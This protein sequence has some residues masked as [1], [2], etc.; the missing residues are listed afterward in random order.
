MFKK[1]TYNTT[2]ARKRSNYEA[3]Y[4]VLREFNGSDNLNMRFEYDSIKEAINASAVI[5]KYTERA[6]MG[7]VA[8]RNGKYVYVF[9][10]EKY[11]G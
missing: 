2:G 9:K 8:H 1:V 6:R 4:E 10:K 11:N 7:L 5:K 3:E